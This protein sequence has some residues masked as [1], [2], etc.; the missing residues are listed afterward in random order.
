MSASREVD[1]NHPSRVDDKDDARVRAQLPRQL[2]DTL[3]VC[4]FASNKRVAFWKYPTGAINIELPL[5]PEG[6]LSD[7]DLALLCLQVT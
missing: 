2:A 5:T 6:L 1:H 4:V 7:A 3:T